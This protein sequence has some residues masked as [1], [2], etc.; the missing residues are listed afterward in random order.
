MHDLYAHL[1]ERADQGFLEVMRP[2]VPP[3]GGAP[4]SP[5]SFID[6]THKLLFGDLWQR[7]HLTLR[8][9][10]LVTLTAMAARGHDDCTV[11]HVTAALRS[12]DVTEADFEELIIQLAFYLGWPPAMSFWLMVTREVAAMKSGEHSVAESP[13]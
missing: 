4:G 2:A 10:R 9:R 12:G 11:Q 8:E 6:L 5:G 13:S 7:P 1:S 3:P